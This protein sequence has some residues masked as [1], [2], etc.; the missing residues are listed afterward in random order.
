MAVAMAM[1]MRLVPVI[2]ALVR[3]KSLPTAGPSTGGRE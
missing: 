3:S 1:P 2:D